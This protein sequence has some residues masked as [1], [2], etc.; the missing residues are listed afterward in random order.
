MADWEP[1]PS[2]R[3]YYR[4]RTDGQR[5]YLVKRDGEECLRLDRPSEAIYKKLD[6]NWVADVQHHVANAHQVAKVAFIADRALCHIVGAH[7]EAK[8]EWINL[9]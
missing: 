3:T 4:S 2:E 7:Q 9:K 6:A 5:A 1:K 8:E